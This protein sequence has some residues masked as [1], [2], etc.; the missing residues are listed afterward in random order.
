VA[1]ADATRR[2]IERDLHDGAQQRLV[3]L[4]LQ[5]R[6]AQAD[7]PSGAD[8]LSA[9]LDQVAA[10]LAGVAD[11]LREFARGIHPAILADG[12]LGPALRT[13]ARRC[14][15][16]VTLDV[17]TGGRLPEPIE[18]CAYHV[19][20]E[21]LANT[22]K[23]SRASTITVQVTT[24][25]DVLDVRVGDNEGGGARFGAESDLIGLKDRVEALGG[26]FTVRDKPGGGTSVRAQLPLAPGGP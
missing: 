21:A 5:L 17:E 16:P 2:R 22:A 20:A 14:P 10:G 13:L 24:T 26:Q 3:S 6:A 23:D 25:G 8:Q 15:I 19:V 18:I 12:G 7:V 1:A 4:V 9:R 11:E